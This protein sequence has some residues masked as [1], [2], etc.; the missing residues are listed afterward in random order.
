MLRN[1]MWV[2]LVILYLVINYVHT[3]VDAHTHMQKLV[4]KTDNY[5]FRSSSGCWS[6]LMLPCCQGP[7]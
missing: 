5:A 3:S 1:C 4:F 2:E 6:F 7:F